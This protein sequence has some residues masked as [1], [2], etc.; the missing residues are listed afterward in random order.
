MNLSKRVHSVGFISKQHARLATMKAASRCS[1]R[2]R[3]VMISALSSC[4]PLTCS[5]SYDLSH[6]LQYNMTLLQMPCDAGE[7]EEL[8]T[9]GRQDSFDIFEEEGLPTQGVFLPGLDFSN[10]F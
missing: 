9:S 2:M 3:S 1:T 7:T 8:N 5:Y 10:S 4:D 6:S